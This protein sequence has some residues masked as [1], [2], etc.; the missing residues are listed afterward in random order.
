MN[1]NGINNSNENNNDQLSCKDKVKQMEI[2]LFIRFVILVSVIL[3]ILSFVNIMNPVILA[4]ANTPFNTIQHFYFWSIFTSSFINLSIINFIFGFAAWIPEALKL[5][6]A[7]GTLKFSFLFFI[8]SILIQVLFIILAYLIGIV[9]HSIT[10]TPSAGIWPLVIATLNL[11]CLLNPN[12]KISLFFIPIPIPAIF[13]PWIL[14]LFFTLINGFRVF[15]IDIL[16]AILYGY[17]YYLIKDKF[18]FLNISNEF[19]NRCENGIFKPLKSLDCNII[20]FNYI[21]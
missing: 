12:E 20:K 19:L 6:R 17:V 18:D 15:Q 10:E 16:A 14:F 3:F 4:M 13:I 2:S 8:H 1:I 11:N 5:E 21:T 7:S 9:F